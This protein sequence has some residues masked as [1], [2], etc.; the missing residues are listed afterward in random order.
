MGATGTWG[1]IIMIVIMFAVFYFF[2]I[3]PQKKQEK[4]SQ[5]MRD[6]LSIGDEI[7]TIGGIVG[8]ITN[9]TEETITIISSRDRTRIQLLKTAVSRVQVAANAPE[10]E[11]DKK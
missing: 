9:I 6:S 7:V 3:R 4:E 1:T 11:E 5:Q 10:S 8:I 2:A